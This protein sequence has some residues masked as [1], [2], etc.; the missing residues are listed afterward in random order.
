M[1]DKSLF[2]SG[3]V[4]EKVIKLPDGSEHTMWLK[5]LPAVDFRRFI[6]AEQS[7]DDDTRATSM[8]KLISMSLCEPDGKPALSMKKA[9]ELNAPATNA[10]VQAIM[11]VNGFG[12]DAKKD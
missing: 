9:L 3:E 5:E 8:A 10:I 11:E 7:D 6:L 4:R 2:V 12:V 1:L